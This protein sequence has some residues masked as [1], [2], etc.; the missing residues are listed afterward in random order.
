MSF[1]PFF[2]L[3]V[4]LFVRFVLFVYS[5]SKVM[6]IF[7]LPC[8][9]G[10]TYY[11]RVKYSI[12]YCWCYAIYNGFRKAYTVAVIYIVSVMKVML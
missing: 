1:V 8:W 4:C 10:L 9:P 2:C 7:V 3:F 5:P 6:N 12:M 11:S